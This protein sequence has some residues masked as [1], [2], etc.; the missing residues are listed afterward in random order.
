MLARARRL[1]HE[2]DILRVYKKGRYGNAADLQAKVL[3]TGGPTTRVAIV[4]SKK[5]S[6]KA[7]VRNRIRRRLAAAVSELWNQLLPGYDIVVT[8]RSDISE[9]VDLPQQLAT[10]LSRSNVIAQEKKRV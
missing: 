6:K 5:I 3:A 2:R 9:A 8:V 7:T 10:A 1:R 4:V